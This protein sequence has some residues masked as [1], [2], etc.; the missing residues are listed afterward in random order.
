MTAVIITLVI[1]LGAGFIAGRDRWNDG[2]NWPSGIFCALAVMLIAGLVMSLA[3]VPLA[4]VTGGFWP[5]YSTG[6]REG[7][8]TKVSVKGAIWK[9]N[10][11][12]I[13]VGTGAMA[14]LQEPF[15]FSISDPDMARFVEMY[16]GEKVRIEY[17][18]W[19]VQPYR[20]GETPYDC[21]SI[22]PIND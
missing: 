7:Y 16:L 17:T 4:G 22:L 12:Q 11:A 6:T 8:I 20:L 5:D 21:V 9:T 19:L 15:S 1:V 14:A 10:E 18:Q 2:W 3:F 13:Q